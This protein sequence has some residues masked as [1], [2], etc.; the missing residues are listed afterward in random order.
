MGLMVAVDTNV[1]IRLIT[2]DDPEQMERA[3][4][5]VEN[6]GIWISKTVTLETAWV[7]RHHYQTSHY[8]IINS[9]RRLAATAGV[10]FESEDRML[11]ALDLSSAG[12]DFA[13]AMHLCLSHDEYLPFHTFDK[14]LSKKAIKQGHTVTLIS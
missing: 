11:E 7:L 1:A 3:M 14:A 13:D 10:C 6:E 8:E 2:G 4:Q 5:L 9:I 12:A